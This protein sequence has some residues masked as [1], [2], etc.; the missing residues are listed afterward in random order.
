MQ[1]LSAQP[2][3]A[4]RRYMLEALIALELLMSFSF[5]GYFHVEPISVTLAYLPVLLAGA[6]VGPLESAAVGAVFGLA[7][8]WKA[9]A[10][11]VMA[12]DRLFSP[13]YS[14]DPV[15]SLILSIGT[16][17]LFGLTVGLLYAAARHRRVS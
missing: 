10:S 8:M 13:L 9:S 5:L 7:S 17:T 16:R 6:L 14:G 1:N 4:M 15:G 11:Y 12:T 2:S 3:G